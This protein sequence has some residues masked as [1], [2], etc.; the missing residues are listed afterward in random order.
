[1]TDLFQGEFTTTKH[2]SSSR[3][4]FDFTDNDFEE[5]SRSF[6]PVATALDTQKCLNLFQSWKKERNLQFPQDQIPDNVLLCG[7]KTVLCKWLCRFI[8]EVR[9]KDGSPYL[10]RTLHHYLVGLQRYIHTQDYL[11]TVNIITDVE[12]RPLRN[13]EDSLYR[14]LH[15]AGIGATVKKTEPLTSGDEDRLWRSGVLDPASPQG[16]LNRIF[17]L[18]GRNFCLR[19]GVEHRYLKL[20]Q[21]KREVVMVEEKHLV[22]YSY[23]EHGSKNRSGGLKQLN[24][25]NKLV[26]QYESN[27]TD[28]CHVLLLDKY[29]SKLPHNAKEKDVFYFKPKSVMPHDES[30]PWY[31]S[32]PLG[33]NKLAEMV[34]IMAME[35]GI[36]KEVTNHSL[37]EHMGLQNF[38]RLTY[39]KTDYGEKWTSFHRRSPSL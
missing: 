1:M 14:R 31:T 13:L 12:F 19:G 9:K 32:V 27:D 26:H 11:S 7:D 8:A 18:N 6:I 35:A 39:L 30:A 20:S 15:A 3:F 10:P 17:F 37:R 21:F 24:Q 34:K 23:T 22:R 36:Q 38:L 2:S 5:H 16:L 4:N 25:D 29:I 33:K 28:R